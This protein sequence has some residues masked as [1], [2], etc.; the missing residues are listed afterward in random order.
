MLSILNILKKYHEEKK[1]NK[2]ET[3]KPEE[4][5][6]A[7]IS[8]NAPKANPEGVFPP[9][10]GQAEN[11]GILAP[12]KKVPAESKLER[13]SGLYKELLDWAKKVY[14]LEFVLVPDFKANF[15]AII[16][17]ELAC[18][19]SEG[20]ELLKLCLADYE[21]KEDALYYHVVNVSILVLELGKG[22]G[23]EKQRLIELGTAG[24]MHDIGIIKF[25]E[26]INKNGKLNE[27]ELR[28]VKE[29]PLSGLEILNKIGGEFTP[30]LIDVISQEHERLDGTGYPK[31][32]KDDEIKEF[33]QIVGLA[34]VYEAMTHSRP[35]R[36]RF[37]P[38]KTMNTIL[39]KKS[40]FSPKVLKI[41]LERIGIFP[42][43]TMVRLN[44]K[45]IGVVAKE[46]FGLPLRPLVMVIFDENGNKLVAEKQIDLSSNLLI[47]IEECMDI[48]GDKVN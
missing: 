14:K 13:A 9:G 46:N 31:G 42:V 29:H 3:G 8:G 19:D 11:S 6:S 12:E 38:P 30:G 21:I 24:F 48:S 25:T 18:L 36:L 33:A 34:D 10:Q 2:G 16:E 5:V 43:G 1:K 22:L 41:F 47:C 7:I 45:E 35:Y 27:E 17:K 28:K 40:E 44:T 39:N 4:P 37:S 32:I 20:R 15:A 26:L 23:Y